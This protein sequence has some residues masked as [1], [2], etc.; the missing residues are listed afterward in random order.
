MR[1]S[2][3]SGDVPKRF[4]MSAAEH[5]FETAFWTASRGRAMRKRD[6]KRRAPPPDRR[7]GH[8]PRN[9][10]DLGQLM[11]HKDVPIFLQQGNPL[12]L[13]RMTIIEKHDPAGH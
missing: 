4:A 11:A 5:P 7:F 13:D 6:N 8:T 2:T 1:Y 3:S 10:G 12:T 9:P